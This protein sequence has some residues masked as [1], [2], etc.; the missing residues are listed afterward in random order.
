MLQSTALILTNFLDHPWI[1]QLR[2]ASLTT[3]RSRMQRKRW[4]ASMDSWASIVQRAAS[5]VPVFIVRR[6]V[7][8][9]R[10]RY[11]IMML[12]WA[13]SLSELIDSMMTLAG[14]DHWNLTTARRWPTH[15]PAPLQNRWVIP[16]LRYRWIAPSRASSD[17]FRA[18]LEMAGPG[19][20]PFLPLFWIVAY[21]WVRVLVLESGLGL[22]DADILIVSP[23][24]RI[25]SRSR[26]HSLWHTTDLILLDQLLCLSFDLAC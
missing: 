9:A 7:I 2:H 3:L 1:T 23:R 4:V 12:Y 22:V 6:L 11:R 13:V 8:V 24:H 5:W 15:L 25:P 19:L 10:C 14:C 26:A 17:L 18:R 16:L 20:P 21:L